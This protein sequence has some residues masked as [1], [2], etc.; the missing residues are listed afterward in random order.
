MQY[1]RIQREGGS[2]LPHSKARFARIS[3]HSIEQQVG[4]VLVQWLNSYSFSF[5]FF[6][7]RDVAHKT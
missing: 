5:S 7:D 6:P 1:A 4:L 2:K 3:M